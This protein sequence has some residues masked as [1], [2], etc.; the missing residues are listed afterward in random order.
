MNRPCRQKLR[1]FYDQALLT[2]DLLCLN[3]GNTAWNQAACRCSP[4]RRQDCLLFAGDMLNRLNEPMFPAS[5][6]GRPDTRTG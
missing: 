5:P 3:C 4:Q 2:P 6:R 1:T